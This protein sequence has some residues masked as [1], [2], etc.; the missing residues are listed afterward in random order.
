MSECEEC[1][2]DKYMSASEK[3]GK[4]KYM[5]YEL[6]DMPNGEFV[7]EVYMKTHDVINA[8]KSSDDRN[9]C[10]IRAETIIRDYVW[11][12]CQR[13]KETPK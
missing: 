5:D 13:A 3:R 7:G 11:K 8:L 2:N 4:L 6:S 1:G 12:C 9:E 10:F